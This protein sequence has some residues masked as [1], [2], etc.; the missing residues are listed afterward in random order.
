MTSTF[1]KN[2]KIFFTSTQNETSSSS[3]L[4]D[5]NFMR[6]L[7]ADDTDGSGHDFEFLPTNGKS[8]VMVTSSTGCGQIPSNGNGDKKIL[9]QEE[10]QKGGQLDQ[11]KASMPLFNQK[12]VNRYEDT[13]LL[14]SNTSNKNQ[15]L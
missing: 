10:A 12:C 5:D 4:L 13:R 9:Q 2:L 11:P 6:F 15:E 7:T 1:L 14:V 8:E 3:I